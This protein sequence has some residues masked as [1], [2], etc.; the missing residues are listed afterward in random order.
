MNNISYLSPIVPTLVKI[1][2]DGADSNDDFAP[3]ENTFVLPKNSVIQV[4]FPPSDED[5]LHRAFT[6][7]RKLRFPDSVL[8][9][10][11]LHGSNFWA[12]CQIEL[13]LLLLL[14]N[15]CRS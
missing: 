4:E 9:A 15:A 14:T 10:F 8:L 3:S 6:T 2:D 11:H 7:I 12:S 5:E 13:I 1:L